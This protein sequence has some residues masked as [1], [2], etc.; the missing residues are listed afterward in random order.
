MAMPLP[1]LVDEYE[2]KCGKTID[3]QGY[4]LLTCKV[5]VDQCGLTTVWFLCGQIVSASCKYHTTLSLKIATPLP[6]E[7]Q[8][9]MLLNH[10]P[11][12]QQN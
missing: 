6:V 5:G 7:G 2:C 12:Q 11:C 3:R 1:L 4:H 8:T 9:S 10:S